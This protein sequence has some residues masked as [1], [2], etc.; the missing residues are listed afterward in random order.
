MGCRKKRWIMYFLNFDYL[1]RILRLE[2]C[3]E[4]IEVYVSSAIYLLIDY[5]LKFIF[6]YIYILYVP[7]EYSNIIVRRPEL[8]TARRRLLYVL[9]AFLNIKP[10]SQN[11][12]GY[13]FWRYAIF[14][15][16]YESYI[17]QKYASIRNFKYCSNDLFENIC[18]WR[19]VRI[20][21]VQTE[22]TIKKYS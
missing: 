7:T 3:G 13:T 16:E 18:N 1:S 12:I 22:I 2:W 10:R 21:F 17:L 4:K 15:T 11:L 14:C 9:N 8:I 6:R 19:N 5:T 20:T